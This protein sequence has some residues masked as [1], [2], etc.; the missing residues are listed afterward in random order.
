MRV[1]RGGS[2]LPLDTNTIARSR[3]RPGVGPVPGG[4]RDRARDRSSPC[5]S[6]R[7]DHALRLLHAGRQVALLADA[8]EHE[9]LDR[10]SRRAR[11]RRVSGSTISTSTSPRSSAR[12]STSSVVSGDSSTATAPSRLHAATTERCD[13]RDFIITPTRVPVRTPHAIR[14]RTIAST[15]RFASAYVNARPRHKKN[16]RSPIARGLIGERACRA[17]SSESSLQVAQPVEARQLPARVVEIRAEVLAE[18]LDRSSA[19][20][21][22]LL[23]ELLREIERA[24]SCS[25]SSSSCS[26]LVARA[27]RDPAR[28]SRARRTRRRAARRASTRRRPAT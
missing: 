6:R 1:A 17:R 13:G 10:S 2:Y 16:V 27:G 7:R 23:D 26:S 18:L 9:H 3:A 22:G 14:P 21:R 20:L 8:A 24:S 19:A 25:S 28:S 15:R 11:A 5:R 4:Q 12:G